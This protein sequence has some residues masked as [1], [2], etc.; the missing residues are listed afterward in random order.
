MPDFGGN[1]PALSE[2]DGSHEL[3]S[4]VNPGWLG[5]SVLQV[6]DLEIS[7]IKIMALD[8]GDEL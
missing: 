6:P 4:G 8:N 2:R 3:L 5:N 7:R 1:M